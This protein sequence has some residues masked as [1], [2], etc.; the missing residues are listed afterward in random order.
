MRN[1]LIFG[2][3]DAANVAT[4][5]VASPSNE[6]IIIVDDR[7]NVDKKPFN[8]AMKII[9]GESIS[10]ESI[11]T[12]ESGTN[13]LLSTP[14]GHPPAGFKF[15]SGEAV[16]GPGDFMI[17]GHVDP[18]TLYG[19]L[20]SGV[21]VTDLGTVSI[22]SVTEVPASGYSTLIAFRPVVGHSYA[23]LLASGKYALMELKSINL[24]ALPTISFRIDYKYQPDGTRNMR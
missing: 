10:T 23:F 1:P 21:K 12:V 7:G 2:L 5:T 20:D 3:S 4:R 17:T 6:P 22:N 16:A 18:F 9:A 11:S 19:F 13:I 24:T 8:E 15:A 14:G